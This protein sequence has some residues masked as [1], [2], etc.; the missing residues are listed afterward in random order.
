MPC[1]KPANTCSDWTSCCLATTDPSHNEAPKLRARTLK[2]RF[3]S[4]AHIRAPS[5][6]LRRILDF[7]GFK[8][9]LVSSWK[10]LESVTHELPS[11]GKRGEELKQFNEVSVPF[12]LIFGRLALW[13]G[14]PV[15]EL[16]S[17]WVW[18]EYPASRSSLVFA[19]TLKHCSERVLTLSVAAFI[20]FCRIIACWAIFSSL[21]VKL[22]FLP[23][24][25]AD[26]RP[27]E[28]FP[29]NSDALSARGS[30][31]RV[32]APGAHELRLANG[33]ARKFAFSVARG[34]SWSIPECPVASRRPGNGKTTWSCC[35]ASPLSAFWILASSGLF[36][37]GTG[38]FDGKTTPAFSGLLCFLK[39][40]LTLRER[41]ETPNSPACR[42]CGNRSPLSRP[43]DLTTV[44]ILERLASFSGEHFSTREDAA[45][46]DLRPFSKLDSI[47][48]DNRWIP[49]LYDPRL[50]HF[51]S[52]PIA[53]AAE[54][55]LINSRLK[56]S[57]SPASISRL[58]LR[59]K[60]PEDSRTWA[61]WARAAS[62]GEVR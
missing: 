61:T 5:V 29:P 28:I 24:L 10:F 26:C 51:L 57:N 22:H 15:N 42:C 4:A 48:S 21:L 56:L 16:P 23:L 50:E 46:G 27:L 36:D 41:G 1:F 59:R 37:A 62:S 11:A 17:V 38:G 32:T 53:A 34:S 35:R 14:C 58:F 44:L 18:G 60:P 3:K 7:E 6:C 31:I 40:N 52:E 30:W 13:E 39:L 43:R 12:C 19:P 2:N 25:G 47:R 49:S 8:E 9:F 55:L 20:S 45:V 54:C 33:F